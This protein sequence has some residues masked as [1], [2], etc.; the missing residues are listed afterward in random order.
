[1]QIG[2]NFLSAQDVLQTLKT[3]IS[4]NPDFIRQVLLEFGNLRRFDRFGAL[5]LLLP[6]AGEDLHVY[7]HTLDAGWA[8]ERSITHVSGF[9][10]E[11][12]TQ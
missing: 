10:T 3:L 11:D 1:M 2:L 12:G 8:V 7:D 6:F 4:Q 9:F 5:V